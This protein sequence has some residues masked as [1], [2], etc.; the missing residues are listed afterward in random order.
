MQLKLFGIW[1]LVSYNNHYII[2]FLVQGAEERKLQVSIVTNNIERRTALT[3]FV[4]TAQRYLYDEHRSVKRA[5]VDADERDAFL[6]WNAA[7]T[8][9]FFKHFRQK[10]AFSQ[11]PTSLHFYLLPRIFH[12]FWR[13]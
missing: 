4:D 6:D 10:N 13:Q 3:S 2:S 9:T 7:T 12:I 8:V 11:C 1:H 5:A